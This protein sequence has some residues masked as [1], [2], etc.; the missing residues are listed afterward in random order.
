MKLGFIGAGNMA[1]AI[2]LGILNKKI[3]DSKDVY[4]F[5]TNTEKLNDF[6]N[7]NGTN[8]AK[9]GIDVAL[10][11]DIVLFA[12]KPNVCASVIE[13]LKDSLKNKAVISIVAG[14]SMKKLSD[15]LDKSTRVLKIMPNTPC[16]VGEG[17]NVFDGS[18]TLNDE[19]IDFAKRIFNAVG[20]VEI[21]AP[22]LMDA[23]TA[24]SGSGPAYVYMFI[25]AMADGGV[26][27]G[28]P[29]QIAYELAAQTV[30]GS[31]KMVIDTGRHPGEL[32]DAVCSPAGTTIDAVA[33]LEKAGFRAAVLD[34]VDACYNKSKEMGK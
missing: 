26:K 20:K 30:L 4:I 7:K 32:K 2:L 1:S 14:W 18:Y 24:V 16:M 28:L 8:A 10:N 3:I 15:S 33:A 5:D 29:R 27:A 25:E 12:I 34:A 22:Y 17:M 6:C 9:N 11:S 19:E 13:E 21:V 23:V 31:A